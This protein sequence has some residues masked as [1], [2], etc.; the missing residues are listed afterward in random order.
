[1]IDLFRRLFRTGSSDLRRRTITVYAVL[2]IA[3]I[4]AWLWA[5]ALFRDQPILLG[6]AL[7]AYGF[8]LRHA[9]DPDHIAAIDNVTRK[10]VQSA[11]DRSRSASGSPRD[12]RPWSH[13]G[14]W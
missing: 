12:I 4:A 8:G 7:I 11:I 6:T 1:M 5:I 3:N 13:W 10:L 14:Q 2:L 9:V